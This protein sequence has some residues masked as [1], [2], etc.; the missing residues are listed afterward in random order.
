MQLSKSVD[1]PSDMSVFHAIAA[2]GSFSGAADTLQLTPSA[3]SRR[4]Q[5]LEARLGV[6]LVN[7]TTRRLSLTEAGQIYLR[8][9]EYILEAIAEAEQ[10]TAEHAKS[11]HGTIRVAASYAFGH[12]R[13]VALVG[14]FL[15]A[16]PHISV[17]LDLTDEVVDLVQAGFD[18]AV[19]AGNFS[20][21]SIISRRLM[22]VNLVTLAAPEY[23]DKHG[24]PRRPSDLS[25][26]ACL[27]RR[28]GNRILDTWTFRGKSRNEPHLQQVGGTFASTSV[29]ALV[30]AAVEGMGILQIAD[31]I[32]RDALADGRLVTILDA[33]APPSPTAFYVA[34]PSRRQL[35]PKVRAFVDFI[36]KR[37]KD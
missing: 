37:V 30:R 6:R 18:V 2:N 36:S 24:T 32:V 7:R 14:E 15:K 26:H 10:E 28:A 35:A 8:H 17:E 12:N 5:R 22:S 4:V 23:L 25:M 29:E 20:D 11:P 13:L 16:Y 21:S 31:L 3:V 19:R 34:Y 9:A 1:S 27:L 33:H